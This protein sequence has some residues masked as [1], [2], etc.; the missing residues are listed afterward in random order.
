LKGAAR[1]PKTAQ[2]LLESAASACSTSKIFGER[3]RGTPL[4]ARLKMI[5][6]M[7][8]AARN[9]GADERIGLAR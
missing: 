3:L 6:C 4:N 1:L 8:G 5:A 2:N 9:A 7:V